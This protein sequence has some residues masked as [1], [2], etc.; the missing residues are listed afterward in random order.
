MDQLFK[1][2]AS[3]ADS[4]LNDL[5][6]SLYKQEEKLTAYAQQQREVCNLL[7]Y[8]LIDYHL[9]VSELFSLFVYVFLL[10]LNAGTFQ[11]CGKC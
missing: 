5:Q 10:I 8:L 1:G 11:S 2:I 9:E 7:F 3:E 6:S 4:L